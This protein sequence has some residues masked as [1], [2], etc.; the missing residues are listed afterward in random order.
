MQ[1][2]VFL[3]RS[4]LFVK[5]THK[6]LFKCDR[7]SWVSVPNPLGLKGCYLLTISLNKAAI[8]QSHE[9][10]RAVLSELEKQKLYPLQDFEEFYPETLE[11][12]QQRLY[13]IK[14]LNLFLNQNLKIVE[15]TKEELESAIT[16]EEKDK[17]SICSALTAR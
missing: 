7:Y 17:L 14:T 1:E 11:Q 16:L 5:G 9:A 12:K 15:M 2:K 6:G 8:F 13:T 3:L 4:N 10:A